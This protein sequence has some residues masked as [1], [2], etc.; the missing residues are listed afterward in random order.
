M[1]V[2]ILVIPVDGSFGLIRCQVG[3]KFALRV[4]L[5]SGMSDEMRTGPDALFVN[6]SLDS[7]LW[8]KE[9]TN[10]AVY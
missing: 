2:N 8:S 9:Y 7:L 5:T 3:L 1:I 4:N 10:D 6:R